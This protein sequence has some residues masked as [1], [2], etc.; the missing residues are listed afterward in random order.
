MSVLF[1]IELRVDCSAENKYLLAKQVIKQ[2][3]LQAYARVA[4]LDDGPRPEVTACSQRCEGRQVDIPLV[5]FTRTKDEE[6]EAIN[7]RVGEAMS[8]MCPSE[9]RRPVLRV[10][11]GGRLVPDHS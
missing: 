6:F 7:A 1:T 8:V 5:E 11:D 9:V 10:I 2:V 3:A 4:L